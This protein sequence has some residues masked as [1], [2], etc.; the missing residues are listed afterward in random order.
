MRVGGMC[1]RA[2]IARAELVAP[3][4]TMTMTISFGFETPL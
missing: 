3:K 4:L 1:T 2:C